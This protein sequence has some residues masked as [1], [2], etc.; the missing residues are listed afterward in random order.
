M[1]QTSFH[2]APIWHYKHKTGALQRFILHF[3][4][5]VLPQAATEQNTFSISIFL[6]NLMFYTYHILYPTQQYLWW[7]TKNRFKVSSCFLILTESWK[8]FWKHI[9]DEGLPL[10]LEMDDTH[11]CQ[12]IFIWTK[13][14]KYLAMPYALW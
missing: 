10:E 8:V 14:D 13:Q 3:T 2:N 9:Y 6:C 4:N 5:I 11:V 7:H 1:C 12:N